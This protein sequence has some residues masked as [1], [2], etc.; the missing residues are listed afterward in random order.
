M[1]FLSRIAIGRMGLFFG[2]KRAEV[3]NCLVVSDLSFPSPFSF[4]DSGHKPNPLKAR[5]ARM[6]AVCPVLPTCGFSKI[7]KSVIVFV[8][9]YMVNIFRWMRP[10]YIKPSQAMSRIC[11]STNFY[12]N[13]PFAIRVSCDLPNLDVRP[14][15]R[16]FKYASFRV[17]VK[18]LGEFV[19]CNH[20]SYYQV[21]NRTAIAN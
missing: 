18:D 7:A 10:N 1:Q 3:N 15:R 5:F 19:M 12:I 4:W 11:S 9:I 13:V 16:P 17:I 2:V 14:W 8:S 6:L 21:L 20:A